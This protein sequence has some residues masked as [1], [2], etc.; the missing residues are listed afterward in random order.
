MSS[1]PQWNK[2]AIVDALPSERERRMTGQA[3]RDCVGYMVG[4]QFGQGLDELLGLAA[5]G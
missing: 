3:F 1:F 2:S 4:D 5:R